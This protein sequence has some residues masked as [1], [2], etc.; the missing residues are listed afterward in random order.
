M[1]DVEEAKFELAVSEA[2]NADPLAVPVENVT[3]PKSNVVD[4]PESDI[5]PLIGKKLPG[6]PLGCRSSLVPGIATNAAPL[7]EERVATI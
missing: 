5:V 4:G 7:R 1:I 2:L 6:K 3:V